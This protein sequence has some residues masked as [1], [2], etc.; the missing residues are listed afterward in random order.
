M[1]V[2][3]TNMDEIVER[4]LESESDLMIDQLLEQYTTGEIKTSLQNVA[5]EMGADSITLKTDPTDITTTDNSVEEVKSIDP[6][7][8]EEYL[9]SGASE[10]SGY[11][12]T[13]GNSVTSGASETSVAST[14][15]A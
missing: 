3:E 1:V 10:T 9:N 7:L 14:T 2:S 13:S 6:A 8:L 11:S 12:E 4:Q 5:N 15:M